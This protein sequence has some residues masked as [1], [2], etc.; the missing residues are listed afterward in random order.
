MCRKPR[1]AIATSTSHPARWALRL[2]RWPLAECFNIFPNMYNVLLFRCCILLE[3]KLTTTSQNSPLLLQCVHN[4]DVPDTAVAT[5]WWHF[6][7]QP[8]S[9]SFFSLGYYM[10]LSRILYQ[11]IPV[12]TRLLPSQKKLCVPKLRYVFLWSEICIEKFRCDWVNVQ[13]EK[14]LL[15]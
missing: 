7:P 15:L 11:P 6:T 14:R 9:R 5:M 12:N 13:V 1:S 10:K 3:I 8:P 4:C 2:I